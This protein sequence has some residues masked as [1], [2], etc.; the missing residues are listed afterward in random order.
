M[1]KS[2]A[3][4]MIVAVGFVLWG[5][6]SPT[7]PET[8]PAEE[9]EQATEVEM[10]TIWNTEPR[11]SAL[12]HMVDDFE[13]RHPN[14]NVN[15]THVEPDAYKTRIRVA[16]GGNQPPDIYFVWSGEKMLHNFVRGGQVAGLNSYLDA[17]EGEWR[18]R[19]IPASLDRFTFDG[20]VRGIPYLL[21]CTFF[22]YNKDM[23]EKHGW[24]VPETF[25]EL[26]TLCE[27]IK[28]ADVTPIALGNVPKWPAHHFPFVLTQR[29]MGK[30]ASEAQYDPTGPGDYSNPAFTRAL[31]MF[32][33]MADRGF[34][35]RS[36]NATTRQ[37][38][39]ALFYSGRAAMF[40]TGTWDFARFSEGGEAPE[41]FRDAWDFF[42]FPAVEGG[43][44]DQEA[45]AGSPDG[46]VLHAD[47]EVQD[48]AATFLKYMTTK[49]AARRF[50]SECQELVQVNEAVTS[51]NAGPKLQKYARMVEE[52]DT[53]T[54]WMDTMMVRTVA[55]EYM[56]GVQALIDGDT[57][58]EG[59]MQQV[60]KRQAAVKERMEDGQ[61][62]AELLDE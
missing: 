21:Q 16:L 37:M 38:A 44:G 49:D 7:P 42:N 4:I 47:S 40:Y 39:R 19:L 60:R 33:E 1:R 13:A 23:F 56:N 57:T 6:P 15:V 34:F 3:I 55:E 25:S 32:Q 27:T 61:L 24:D 14:I 2:I 10:W 54:P 30:K 59:V 50:V 53:I 41:E 18:K 36:P 45:L 62:P 58:P 22:F 52:A 46:Y 17:N 26:L 5:C 9:G 12:A 48:A 29:L 8:G 51:E 11:K 28:Q 43:K 31:S 35:N 20:T